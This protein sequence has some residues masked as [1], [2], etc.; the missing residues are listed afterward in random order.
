M[1]M[2]FHRYA[3]PLVIL[4][5]MILTRRFSEFVN[6]F[7]TIRNEELEDQTK[8]EYW[9]HRVFDLSFS[10]FLEKAQ[11]RKV[12]TTMTKAEAMNTVKESWG[13][14]NGFNPNEETV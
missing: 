9:L 8:W 11:E 13:I 5:K 7:V 1:D 12:E 3:S 14:V 6:Q 10:E 2:L 4:D